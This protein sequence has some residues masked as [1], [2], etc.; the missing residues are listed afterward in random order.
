M[1]KH[2]H[3][4][5]CHKNNNEDRKLVAL[6]DELFPLDNNEEV[7]N[8]NAKDT[9]GLISS[10]VIKECQSSLIV[11]KGCSGFFV[12]NIPL[13]I[14]E[15]EVEINCETKIELDYPAIEI[16]RVKKNVF[17]TECR[18]LNIPKKVFLK[19]FIRKNIEYAAVGSRDSREGNSLRHMTFEVPFI[20]TTEIDYF[21][22]PVINSSRRSMEVEIY[23][24]DSGESNIPEKINE[25]WEYF[26]EKVYCKPVE[27]RVTDIDII[28]EAD[29]NDKFMENKIFKALTEKITLVLRLKLIQNQDVNIYSKLKKPSRKKSSEDHPEDQ[30]R[31]T[32]II[33]ES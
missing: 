25:S 13:V 26:N 29:K 16:K 6:E 17:I 14:S 28:E 11:P 5:E 30:Q 15:F 27:A 9:Q 31:D 1:G 7:N 18:L 22:P 32:S 8:K 12:A 3:S 19:G 10:R 24:S 23:E 21:I 2:S 33:N 4:H 20:C